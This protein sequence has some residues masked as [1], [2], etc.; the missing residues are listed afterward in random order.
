MLLIQVRNVALFWRVSG[1]IHVVGNQLPVSV[2][3][4][5]TGQRLDAQNDTIGIVFQSRKSNDSE[6]PGRFADT[7]LLLIRL[8]WFSL[9]KSCRPAK[10]EGLVNSCL[11]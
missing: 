4:Q 1:E 7:E 5:E 2:I 10:S 11:M 3:R 9:T 6:L 8:M